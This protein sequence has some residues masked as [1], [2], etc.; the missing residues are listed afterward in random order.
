MLKNGYASPNLN[1]VPAKIR[2]TFPMN[3]K[4]V[5]MDLKLR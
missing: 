4:D 1:D 3:V 5:H 2:A